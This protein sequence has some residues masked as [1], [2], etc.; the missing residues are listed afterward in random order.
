MSRSWQ[1]MGF[2]SYTRALLEGK[3]QYGIRVT[4]DVDLRGTI[5]STRTENLY[6]ELDPAEKP[7]RETIGKED[8]WY[9]EGPTLE[10][11]TFPDGRV[12]E[13]Y[14][15]AEP[16]RGGPCTFMALRDAETKTPIEETLWDQQEID[17]Y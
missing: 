3:K 12:W 16:G 7:F 13:S 9:G 17:G 6:R 5:I 15:Q 2:T 10:K 4:T 8:S 1:Y 11:F 14:I